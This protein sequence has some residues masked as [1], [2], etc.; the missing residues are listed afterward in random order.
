[1]LYIGFMYILLVVVSIAKC[2]ARLKFGYIKEKLTARVM[3][4]TTAW[5]GRQQHG[6]DYFKPVFYSGLG[7]VA[8]GAV[9]ALVSGIIATPPTVTVC[10]QAT[11]VIERPA[12]CY[13]TYYARD[14]WGNP[15]AVRRAIPCY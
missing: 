13:E 6:S 7:C 11:M 8:V 3:I 15:I 4:T 5:A 12:I 10:P 2:P 9:S 1:L 14:P